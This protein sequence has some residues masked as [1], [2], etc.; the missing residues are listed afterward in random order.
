MK[1]KKV[2]FIF[3]L[4]G[5]Q[6]YISSIESTKK[7]AGGSI[8]FLVSCKIR[9]VITKIRDKSNYAITKIRAVIAKIRAVIIKIRAAII[10]IREAFL[11]KYFQILF[12]STEKSKRAGRPD[13]DGG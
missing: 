3:P 13:V 1:G 2:V 8:F 10:K 6:Y 11:K 4:A 12:C 9:A 7:W 5:F